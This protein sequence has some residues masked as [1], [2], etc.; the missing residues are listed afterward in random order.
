MDI[1][2]LGTSFKGYTRPSTDQRLSV[3]TT[4]PSNGIMTFTTRQPVPIHNK[5][6]GFHAVKVRTI[7]DQGDGMQVS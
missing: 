2:V 3:V 5:S 4:S 7:V 6:P 1:D